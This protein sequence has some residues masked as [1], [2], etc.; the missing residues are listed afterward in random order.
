MSPRKPEAAPP[1][2]MKCVTCGVAMVPSRVRQVRVMVQPR[3]G[4][5]SRAGTEAS[6][7]VCPQ[8]GRISARVEDLA[9][10]APGA[11]RP[12]GGA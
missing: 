7:F 9:L 10:F 11:A 1:P 8:C 2:P 6:V 5:L 12:R 4:F 3:K